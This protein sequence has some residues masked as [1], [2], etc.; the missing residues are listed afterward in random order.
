MS[1][2]GIIFRVVIFWTVSSHKP[3]PVLLMR[4]KSQL[5]HYM[6]CIPIL[7]W[8]IQDISQQYI[9]FVIETRG[10]ISLNGSQEK[11]NMI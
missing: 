10:R 3:L 7:F 1:G 11:E 5:L 8:F 9:F 6:V 2:C 4:I